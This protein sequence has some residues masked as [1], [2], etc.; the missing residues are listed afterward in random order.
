[1]SPSEHPLIVAVDP[2]PPDATGFSRLHES[3]LVPYIIPIIFPQKGVK[4]I[5]H[6]IS[7][8]AHTSLVEDHRSIGNQGI[9]GNTIHGPSAKAFR[10]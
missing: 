1:M 2:S 7:Q 3:L 4:T 10:I 9:S 5:V 8:R 6:M